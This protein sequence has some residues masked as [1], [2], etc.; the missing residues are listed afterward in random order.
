MQVMMNLVLVVQLLSALASRLQPGV[1][2]ALELDLRP[3]DDDKFKTAKVKTSKAGFFVTPVWRTDFQQPWLNLQLTTDD[4][5]QLGL[6]ITRTGIRTVTGS[7]KSQKTV[8]EFQD[9]LTATAQLPA[10][11]PLSAPSPAEPLPGTELM[12]QG[13]SAVARATCAPCT[14]GGSPTPTS[15]ADAMQC[16]SQLACQLWNQ[17]L[18]ALGQDLLPARP[19]VTP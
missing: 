2:Q 18:A 6:T 4:G 14:V 19:P 1:H 9:V 12:V 11:A 15:A 5:T 3:S 10:D 8:D 7:G 16:Q 17:A 13:R